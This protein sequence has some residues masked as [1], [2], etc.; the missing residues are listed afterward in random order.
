MSEQPNNQI[1][2]QSQSGLV[3]KDLLVPISIVI[4]GLFIGA[5]LYFGGSQASPTVAAPTPTPSGGNAPAEE[6]DNTGLVAEVTEADHI[7]GDLNA[8]IKIVEYSDFD[9][10]FCGRFHIVMNQIVSENPDVAWVYRHFPLEQLHPQAP[11][12]AAASECVAE[13]GGEEAFWSFT[14]GYFRVRDG[15]DSRAHGVVINELAVA[16]GVSETDLTECLDSGRTRGAVEADVSNA[17][18]TGGRG[19]PWS[20]LIGPSGKTYPINGAL[21][22]SAVE[23]LIN[24]ALEEA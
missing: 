23:Q 21:P 24:V 16:S 17:L 19:T 5:G 22:K 18:E 11:L 20:V 9:C 2:H 15:G 7:K 1:T 3:V 12:V 8:P 4:A 6:A 13:L 10:P 14:D